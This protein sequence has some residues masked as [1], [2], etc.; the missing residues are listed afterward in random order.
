MHTSIHTASSQVC[1]V[2]HFLDQG[3]QQLLGTSRDE[4]WNQPNIYLPPHP[5]LLLSSPPPLLEA[6]THRYTQ[7]HPKLFCEPL[8]SKTRATQPIRY[9]LVQE[10]HDAKSPEVVHDGQLK[11]SEG[12]VKREEN[13][14][15]SACFDDRDS[16]S[17]PLVCSGTMSNVPTKL[18]E[19]W[20][21]IQ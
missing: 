14:S 7:H 2:S 3:L 1:F 8:S 5:S 17:E 18:I 6:C 20:C 12:P 15:A 13:E 21:G 16:L 10:P 4:L 11:W 9:R 19:D